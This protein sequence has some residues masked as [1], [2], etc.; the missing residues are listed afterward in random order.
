MYKLSKAAKLL[1][2][3]KQ[4]LWNW[5]NDGK[6][7]FHKI[8][9][10]CYITQETLDKLL[11]KQI[12]EQKTIIY[13][14]VSS[15]INKS[16]LETQAER[17]KNY[18]AAKGYKVHRIIKE[19]GSGINDNRKELINL[20]KNIDFDRIVVEHK[21]RLTRTGF[22]YIK[23]LL[24]QQGKY[25]EVINETDD[26]KTDLIQDFVSIITSYCARIYGKRRSAR[27]TEKL[28]ESL[29]SNENK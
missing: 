16:N 24:E 2:I 15:S 11:G 5:K 26:D 22:N 28:I 7:E 12:Y 23:I 27:K 18:C 6:I 8:G 1:D 14:R 21:D 17:V 25:I 4:T 20:L 3:S 13:C 19:I 9:N 29:K 10:L